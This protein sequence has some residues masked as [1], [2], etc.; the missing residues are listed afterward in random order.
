MTMDNSWDQPQWPLRSK[1]TPW[2]QL[3]IITVH[4]WM[5]KCWW[6][7]T[8]WFL[9]WGSL[10]RLN[11]ATKIEVKTLYKTKHQVEGQSRS[12]RKA[13]MSQWQHNKLN[14]TTKTRVQRHWVLDEHQPIYQTNMDV[15]RKTSKRYYDVPIYYIHVR[16]TDKINQV[17]IVSIWNNWNL[18][19]INN[20]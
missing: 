13:L 16:Q 10:W 14:Q 20:F 9:T 2:K 17:I 3:K 19:K 8:T 12:K 1:K 18:I 15:N 4:I 6:F 11:K 7:S 5:K